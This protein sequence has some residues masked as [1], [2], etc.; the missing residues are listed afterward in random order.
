MV[1]FPYFELCATK[2]SYELPYEKS[3]TS[4]TN[5]SCRSYETVGEWS[6]INSSRSLSRFSA[7][8]EC[9]TQ[10]VVFKF[11]DSE[12]VHIVYIRF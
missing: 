1:F 2:N 12:I 10:L 6:V 9:Y 5:R 3:C 4:L 7:A 11:Y 8:T